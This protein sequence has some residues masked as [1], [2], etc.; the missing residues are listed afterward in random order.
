M[1]ELQIPNAET[2][3]DCRAGS[4]VFAEIKQKTVVK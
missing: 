2:V 1:C 3:N 4:Q